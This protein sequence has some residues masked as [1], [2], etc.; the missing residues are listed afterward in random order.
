MMNSKTDPRRKFL[1]T[2]FPANSGLYV[3][4]IAGAPAG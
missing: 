4:A 3:G 1:F 2:Q